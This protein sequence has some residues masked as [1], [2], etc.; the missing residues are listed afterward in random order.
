M[1]TVEKVRERAQA[2]AQAGADVD[3]EACHSEEDELWKDVLTA[4]AEGHPQAV[5]L[6]RE[7]LETQRG[8]FAR[9]CA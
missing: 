8:E 3:D 7:A 1:L 9:W 6:A 5:E 4:I 2:L